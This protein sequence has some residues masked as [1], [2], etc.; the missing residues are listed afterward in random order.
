M[1]DF[2]LII[3]VHNNEAH[4]EQL[5]SSI[6]H[7][8]FTGTIECLF[9]DD[10]STDNSLATL[11]QL[12]KQ[13]IEPKSNIVASVIHDGK[14]LKQGTRRNQGIQLAQGKWLFF[15]DSDDYIHTDALRLCFE[16]I[17]QQPNADMV[18]F[19][20]FFDVDDEGQKIKKESHAVVN[21]GLYTYSDPNRLIGAECEYLLNFSIYFTVNKV[22]NKKFLMDNQITFGEGYFY[23]DF[24]FYVRAAIKAE[25]IE[26][27]TNVLY[28][29]RVHDNST[30][31]IIETDN[32]HPE[33]ALIAIENSLKSFKEIRGVYS[34]YHGIK[35]FVNRG[36]LYSETR[37]MYTTKEQVAYIRSMIQLIGRYMPNDQINFPVGYQS[38]L[39]YA[40]FKIGYYQR[41]DAENI[42]N[43]YRLYRYNFE[44]LNKLVRYHRQDKNSLKTKIY[45]KM[46]LKRASLYQKNL[47][48]KTETSDLYQLKP[49]DKIL[50]L[51]FDYKYQGNSKYLFNQLAERYDY[52][53]LRFACHELPL[54]DSYLHEAYTVIP[55]S[56]EFREWVRTAKVIIAESWVPLTIELGPDQVLIQLWHGHPFKKMLFDSP[57]L[58]VIGWNPGHKKTKSMDINRWNYL[59]SE[60]VYSDEKFK[61]SLAVEDELLFRGMY[62]RNRWLLDNQN[63][64]EL[65]Q[66]LRAKLGIPEN[67]K[68]ILYVP[69]WR[70]YNFK[71]KQHLKN[72]GY[73]I[74]YER[75][76]K[77]L[78]NPDDYF[79]IAKGHSM[80]RMNNQNSPD[81]VLDIE[82]DIQPYYL[83]TDILI[84]DYSSAIFDGM[85][86]DIPFYLFFKDYDYY[87]EIRGVYEDAMEDFAKVI[88]YSE[89]ELATQLDRGEF[90]INNK[91]RYLIETEVEITQLIHDLIKK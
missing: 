67:K 69:T 38:R 48:L 40:I 81:V 41:N 33:D 62:P 14:N 15:I 54:D 80:D 2:T 35:Y 20:Y 84:S 61:T 51:G 75:L 64:E 8:S 45:R 57:E 11:K 68:V 42:V 36:L 44:E 66:E 10:N 22:Y 86:L 39:Y 79:F 46:I 55:N 31:A 73:L 60:T 58:A 16:R 37:S 83:I 87:E 28:Y 34:A 65:K 12:V 88:S 26:L 72:N 70:D 52:D 4:L 85:L 50:M 78:A 49:E 17:T 3:P 1:Y 23:E 6:A 91:E 27:L 71:E 82:E 77:S 32:K 47:V 76:K 7:Q 24:E 53:T 30:T 5:V 18:Y 56:M 59:L 43:V 74:N 19:N 89:K 9:I 63:N 21:N 29:V 25:Q 90:E 13:Y